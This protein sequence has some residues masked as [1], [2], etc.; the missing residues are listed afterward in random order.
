MAE[1][2]G[3]GVA[4][5][6]ASTTRRGVDPSKF[7]GASFA[8]GSNLAERVSI[9]ERKITSLKNIIKLRKINTKKLL[10]P[11]EES[12]E[13]DQTFNTNNLAERLNNISEALG[14]LFNLK[15]Q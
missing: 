7:M 1:V 14:V 4:L 12:G 8:A 3:S 10:P 6:P 5:P 15:K 11:S 13:K 2:T 9:N